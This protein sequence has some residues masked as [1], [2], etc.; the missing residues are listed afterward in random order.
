MPDGSSVSQL[1]GWTNTAILSPP[2]AASSATGSRTARRAEFSPLPSPTLRS[3]I[4]GAVRRRPLPCV[5]RSASL[6]A[7]V[8]LVLIISRPL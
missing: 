7:L 2:W 1:P 8:V 3:L 5:E 6:G 4:R